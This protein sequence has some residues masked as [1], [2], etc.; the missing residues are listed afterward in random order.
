M[1]CRDIL[2]IHDSCHLMRRLRDSGALALLAPRGLR[3][4]LFVY[5]R[6]YLRHERSYGIA[7]F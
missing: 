7:E 2:K 1:I 4:L 3:L 6:R 5:E